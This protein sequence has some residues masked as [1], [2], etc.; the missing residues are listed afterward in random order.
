M[1]GKKEVSGML[2]LMLQPGFCVKENQII[3]VNAAAQALLITPGSD[4]RELLRTG[5]AEY[6]AFGSGCLYLKLK[7][8]GQDRGASVT[9]VADQDVFLLDPDP[10]DSALRHLALAAR[11]LREPLNNLML[12]A[13]GL[14]PIAGPEGKDHAAR[15]NRS[16]YQMLRIL[17]NMSDAGHSTVSRQE[18]LDLTAFFQEIFE[19]AQILV[20]QAGLTLSYEGP[21]KS[22]LSLAD[23]AQLERAVLNLLSNAIKFTPKG[24]SIHASLTL[25]GRLLQLRI[26]DTGSGIAENIRSSVF[27]RYLRQPG[28][29]DGRYGL[30]LGMVLIRSAA[31]NHGGTVLIDQPEVSGTRVTMTMMVRQNGSGTLRSPVMRVDYAGERDHGRIELSDC[32]PLSAY[33]EM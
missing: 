7:L 26:R 19:K 28:I 25:H 31:A 1:E 10:E 15:L 4:V 16:L 14:L 9:R 3:Q 6:D 30:G 8:P 5:Q 11:E 24:G 22:I 32:L 23:G 29:E 2:D 17:G 27:A 20:A 33:E 13:E 18:V 12:S 21:G